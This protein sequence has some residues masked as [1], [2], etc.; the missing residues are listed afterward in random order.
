MPY[1]LRKSCKR[2]SL[3]ARA[4]LFGGGSKMRATR[5]RNESNVVITK[6][7]AR[8]TKRPS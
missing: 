4:E 5:W 3:G 2:P 1:T 6:N 8:R 7:I